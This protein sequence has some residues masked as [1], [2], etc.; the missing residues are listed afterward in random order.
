MSPTFDLNLA[1]ALVSWNEN[2]TDSWWFKN[3]MLNEHNEMKRQDH[4][5]DIS[6]DTILMLWA[7]TTQR[8]LKQKTPN[9]FN[10]TWANEPRTT[11]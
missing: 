6:A 1:P 8:D 9:H 5:E 7:I 2:G 3:E 10:Q 11:K 4:T